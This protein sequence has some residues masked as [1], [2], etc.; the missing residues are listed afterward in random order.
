MASWA[1]I[2]RP[3]VHPPRAS[4]AKSGWM[5]SAASVMARTMRSTDW[6][7]VLLVLAAFG[8]LVVV[9]HLVIKDWPHPE[10]FQIPKP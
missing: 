4:A 7:M 10:R 5:E 8:V 2:F 6:K 9:T 3:N 1:S